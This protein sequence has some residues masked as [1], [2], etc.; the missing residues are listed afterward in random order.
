MSENK[1]QGIAL[2][3]AHAGAMISHFRPVVNMKPKVAVIGQPLNNEE[4]YFVPLLGY[5][6][7]WISESET[8]GT[9]PW[10]DILRLLTEAYVKSIG[11]PDGHS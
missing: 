3:G 1:Y 11:N 7:F 2:G 8:K 10:D 4:Y 6:G 5:Q 9:G